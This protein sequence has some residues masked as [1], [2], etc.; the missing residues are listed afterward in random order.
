MYLID[1]GAV[2]YQ[3]AYDLHMFIDH[4]VVK[5][6]LSALQEDAEITGVCM[7]VTLTPP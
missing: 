5:R 7:N 2:A 6:R 1:V 3:Q 4:R